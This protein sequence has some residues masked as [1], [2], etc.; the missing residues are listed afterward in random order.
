MTR[1]VCVEYSDVG[2]RIRAKVPVEATLDPV[3]D[4]LRLFDA[5]TGAGSCE[6]CGC[7][8]GFACAGGCSWV[9]PGIC[10][11]CFREESD[12]VLVAGGHRLGFL[13]IG[14]S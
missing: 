8:D 7:T 10:S 11:T 14:G 1:M 2:S 4:T 3:L 12:P 9:A 6:I 5:A 13:H